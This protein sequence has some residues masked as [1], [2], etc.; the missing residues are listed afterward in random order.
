LPDVEIHHQTGATMQ[1]QVSERYRELGANAEAS[2]FIDDMVAAYSWA[3]LIICRAGA[4]TVSEVAAM[5]LPA[6]FVPLPNAIDNHQMANARFL[7]DAQAACIL[8]Q[9]ELNAENLQ[10]LIAKVKSRYRQMRTAAK[11]CARLD[12][13]LAVA[14]FCIEEARPS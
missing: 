8:P 12:A 3:D 2:A 14:E 7:A 4:M 11:S 5:A 9:N 13:T 10:A 6:I 1:A